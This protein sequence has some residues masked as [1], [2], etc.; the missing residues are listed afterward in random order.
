VRLEKS[1][2]NKAQ[3]QL[4]GVQPLMGRLFRSVRCPLTSRTRCAENDGGNFV[5]RRF[6]RKGS[7]RVDGHGV[8]GCKTLSVPIH[9]VQQRARD[10][11]CA[12]RGVE[13]KTRN[14]RNVGIFSLGLRWAAAR[15]PGHSIVINLF[16]D[17]YRPTSC[18]ERALRCRISPAW[19]S[20]TSCRLASYAT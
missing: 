11:Q 17:R 6:L 19:L 3:T 10:L 18:A 12:K 15:L 9:F 1:L 14:R 5:K 8:S 2:Q 4:L 20:R 7:Q 13:V 16:L